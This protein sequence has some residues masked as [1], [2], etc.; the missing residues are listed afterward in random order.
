MSF[1]LRLEECR[2]A[3]Q[4]LIPLC[5]ALAELEL[6]ERSLI[7]PELMYYLLCECNRYTDAYFEH[8]ENVR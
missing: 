5:H 3:A 8:K 4:K 6:P 7:Y 2:L 1:K